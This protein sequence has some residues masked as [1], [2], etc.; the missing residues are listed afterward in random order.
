MDGRTWTFIEPFSLPA[1]NRRACY[2][3]QPTGQPG[4][5]NLPDWP[6]V[7]TTTT[8]PPLAYVLAPTATAWPACNRHDAFRPVPVVPDDA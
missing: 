4:V 5:A 8:I 3:R 2:Q 7:K 1:D 6:A